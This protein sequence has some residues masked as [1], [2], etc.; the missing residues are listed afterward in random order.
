MDLPAAATRPD[1]S[2]P[3]VEGVALPPLVLAAGEGAARAFLYFFVAHIRNR[4]TRR[5]YARQ[6]RDFLAWC[7]ARGLGD[8]RQVRTE[9]AAAYVEALARGRLETS[10][11]KQALAAL[12][13]LF[14][15]LVVRQ[16]VPAG[17][18]FAAV[19][20]PRLVVDEGRTPCLDGGQVVGLF[21]AIPADTLVGLR[22]RA[23]VGLMAYT[24]ARIGAA[25][26][27]DVGDY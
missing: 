7:E 24:F 17:S 20:G 4:H 11:V 14:D 9:H 8:V 19:R 3:A 26:A 6:A 10:S 12:R 5:A 1:H 18:P 16:A 23:L 2:A 15:W 21:E 22:D 27:M 13:A 25:L